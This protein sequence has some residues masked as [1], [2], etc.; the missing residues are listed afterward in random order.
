[1]PLKHRVLDLLPRPVAAAVRTYRTLRR[2]QARDR[3]LREHHAVELTPRQIRHLRVLPG[4][5]E[6]LA[7]L[8]HGGVVAEVGVAFG[9][10]SRQIM[11]VCAPRTLYLVDLWD[12]A[13][14]RYGSPALETTRERMRAEIDAGR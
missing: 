5:A 12:P 4:R 2:N 7:L 10:F 9:E 3:W 11:D 1:M 6:L 8:P 13:E 14:P